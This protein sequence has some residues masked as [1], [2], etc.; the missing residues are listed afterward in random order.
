[1]SLK[2]WR[3]VAIPHE[4]VLK[5]NFQQ[6]EFAADLSRVHQKSA[7]KEYQNPTL[8]FERTFITEGM[9]HLFNSVINRLVGKGGEPVT[10]LQTSFGGGKTH[11]M[12]AVYHL[13]SGEVP[14]SDLQGIS[15]ILDAAR[16]TEL[17]KAK[18]VVLDGINISA[19]QPRERDGLIIHTLWGDLA[20]QLGGA[21]AYERIK[22]S[23]INGTSPAKDLIASIL[24]DYS[25][26]VI[27]VDELVAYLRQFEQGKTYTGGTFDS[28]LTFIQALTEALKSVPNAMILASLP[29]SKM[30]VGSIQGQMALDALEKYFGRV[31]A[32][33]KPVATEEAF[34]IVR[35]RLF[36]RISDTKAMEE[37]CRSYA[38]FYIQNDADFPHETLESLYF[39]RMKNAYPIH[40]EIFDRLYQDWSTLDKFQRTRGVL[41]LMA[42][43]IHRL[44][45]DDNKD[46]LILPGSLPLYDSDV[47]NEAINYLPLGWDPVIERDIDGEKSET[48]LYIDSDSRFGAVQAAKRTARTIF[49]GSAPS[50]ANQGVRGIELSKIILGCAQPGQ[51][52]AVYKDALHR[53]TDRLHYLN[54]GN[55]RYWFDTRPNLRREMEERKR[56]FHDEEDI[57]PLIKRTLQ[58]LLKGGSF[59][60]I[61]IF[62]TGGDVPDDYLLRL[63][64]LT[65][66]AGYSKATA[67]LAID[68]ASEILKTTRGTE[69]R[70]RQNRLVFMAPDY[71]SISRLK[72]FVRRLLAWNSIVIDIRDSKLNLDQ[73]QRKQAEGS[74]EEASE[75]LTRMV[76]EAYR[77]LLVPMQ[78][79]RAGTPL[80]TIQ[81]EVV[82]LSSA[83][84]NLAQEVEIKLKEHE[85]LVSEWSP[86]HLAN[87]LKTWFWKDGKGDAGALDVWQKSCCY[88]YFPKLKTEDVFRKTLATGAS[89]TDFFATAL[90]KDETG[91]YQGLNFGVAS[92]N[93]MLDSNV[94]L[95]DPET[96][97][98]FQEKIESDN[99]ASAAA[100]RNSIQN[101]ASIGQNTTHVSEPIRENKPQS[102]SIESAFVNQKPKTSFF[103]TT[104]LSALKAKIEFSEVVD[105][106][107]QKFAS[108]HNVKLSIRVEISA[109][110]LAGFD[111]KIQRDVKENCSVLKFK[112]AEFE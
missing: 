5:G 87:I 76:R 93:I 8:F 108:Q 70:L 88:L 101:H 49:L 63:V 66:K 107:V 52:I 24:A 36:V 69:P 35:R 103:G 58:E 26:C 20:S 39:E 54:T 102:V 106:V 10:Q 74:L 47:R 19:S 25:P 95:V 68:E 45:K 46:S 53:L 80:N 3:E 22:D 72:E 40:P 97:T 4:D 51:P 90:G 57:F 48:T 81:W 29:E 85:L 2:P 96:A 83:A 94:L 62:T 89:S 110:N 84:K 13:V 50:T 31:Q 75:G 44:W 17:P 100:A 71:D 109:E 18:V 104:E 56:R 55:G 59:E 23:D 86:I 43:V 21:E 41:K 27:L 73:L 65:P 37:V 34:E 61:H 32:L 92:P 64:I 82:S 42:K 67:N 7:S 14:A 60:G 9:R 1:M 99:A 30:E 79:V 91:K 12:L 11:T 78:E 33:W 6:A 15:S 28:N 98:A 16:V 77:W 111:E 112:I 38:D 105:E